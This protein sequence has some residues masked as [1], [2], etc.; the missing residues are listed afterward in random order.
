LVHRYCSKLQDH[1]T[2]LLEEYL[3]KGLE[4][5]IRKAAHIAS[6]LELLEQRKKPLQSPRLKT[7]RLGSLTA[8][9]KC[10]KKNKGTSGKQA[11]SAVLHT[12]PFQAE[13]LQCPNK[14]LT[15]YLQ[16]YIASIPTSTTSKPARIDL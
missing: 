16:P 4:S 1:Q 5:R 7:L 14:T 15:A 13:Y 10:S 9:E 12:K 3:V 11:R 6:I 8:G 2:K